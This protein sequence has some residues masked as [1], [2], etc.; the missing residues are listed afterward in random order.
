MVWHE[1]TKCMYTFIREAKGRVP[2]LFMWK[3]FPCRPLNV[4]PGN[5]ITDV[6]LVRH[7]TL[8]PKKLGLGGRT[9][10]KIEGPVTCEV[11]CGEV[12]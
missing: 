8:T 7:W 12:G 5:S 4:V 9:P 10:Q 3:V 11:R 2:V 1:A 6:I